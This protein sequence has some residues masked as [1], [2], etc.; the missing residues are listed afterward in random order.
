MQPLELNQAL[1]T[2]CCVGNRTA[3]AAACSSLP[4]KRL[5]LY[6]KIIKQL[7][8]FYVQLFNSEVYFLNC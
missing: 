8:N 3:T 5:E 6:C 4:I 2:N 7:P 1:N